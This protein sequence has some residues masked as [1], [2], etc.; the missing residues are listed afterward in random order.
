MGIGTV[1]IVALISRGSSNGI[2]D[3]SQSLVEHTSLISRFVVP[4]GRG[5][6]MRFFKGPRSNQ[7]SYQKFSLLS[8]PGTHLT[9][10]LNTSSPFLNPFHVGEQASL[11]AFLELI[12]CLV[13]Y[14]NFRTLAQGALPSVCYLQLS[15]ARRVVFLPL[16]V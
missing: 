11:A 14:F 5:P 13:Q 2:M 12:L 7:Q 10:L 6:C 4:R 16:V 9:P 8:W 3:H 1:W 15:F